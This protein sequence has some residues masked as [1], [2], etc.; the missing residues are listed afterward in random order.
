[1]VGG[2]NVGPDHS[3]FVEYQC[4]KVPNSHEDK[5]TSFLRLKITLKKLW[6]YNIGE[7]Q[8]IPVWC[9]TGDINST[10]SYIHRKSDNVTAMTNI[11]SELTEEIFN[12][13]DTGKATK[14]RVSQTIP[15]LI[16]VLT[17]SLLTATFNVCRVFFFSFWL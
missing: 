12:T 2:I 16:I 15:S 6:E 13:A 10:I 11:T 3:E 5:G 17:L 14:S 9:R 1:M 8:T 4:K 7:E